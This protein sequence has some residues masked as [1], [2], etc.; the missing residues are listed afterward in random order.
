MDTFDPVCLIHGKRKSEH[1]CLY[2]CLC[3]KSLTVEECHL[4][5]DGTRED[6]C[7]ECAEMEAKCNPASPTSSPTPFYE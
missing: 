3:F 6:V 5:S 4:L 7:N 2:C 1:H